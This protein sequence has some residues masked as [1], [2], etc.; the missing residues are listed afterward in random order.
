VIVRARFKP[1]QPVPGEVVSAEARLLALAHRIET[2][3][4]SGI[5]RS[6]AEVARALGISRARASQLM[7][8]RWATVGEQERILGA[9]EG[10]DRG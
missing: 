1:A 3:V 6:V 2:E 9:A 5:F 4:E 8:R 7:R 10:G